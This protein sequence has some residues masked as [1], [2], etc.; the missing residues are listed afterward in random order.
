[1]INHWIKRVLFMLS[2][3]VMLGAGKTLIRAAEWDAI[4]TAKVKAIVDT[5]DLA[6]K[7]YQV[8]NTEGF[9]SGGVLTK[10]K[11]TVEKDCILIF[12]TDYVGTTDYSIYGGSKSENVNIHIYTKN[13]KKKLVEYIQFEGLKG[14]SKNPDDVNRFD[15]RIGYFPAGTYYVEA[16]TSQTPKKSTKKFTHFK[17]AVTELALEDSVK[18]NVEQIPG[19]RKFKL[20]LST[21]LGDLVTRVRLKQGIYDYKDCKASSWGREAF[22]YSD[23][24]TLLYGNGTAK[25]Y[26]G[27]SGVYITKTFYNDKVKPVIS[28]VKN[29]KVYTGSVTIRYEDKGSGIK[30]ATINGKKLRNGR[31]IKKKG[32][33]E[34]IVT[35]NAGNTKK[36]KFTIK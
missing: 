12:N 30:S 34:V 33:Y 23:E 16:K 36:V 29:K 18:L 9:K 8:E 14:V 10:I 25:I 13:A 26:L 35:D 6:S 22:R 1:M 28:G 15:K 11:F 27:T 3:F 20:Q 7:L 21:E 4:E 19:T 17:L 24:E 2:F 32:D 5:E 31:K